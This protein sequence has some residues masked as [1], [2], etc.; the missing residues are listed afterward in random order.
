MLSFNNDPNL[1]AAIVAG[2][3]AHEAA[4]EIV[5]GTYWANG[6]GCA[7]GCTLNAFAKAT[8]RDFKH[9]GDHV[10]YDEIFGSGGRIIAKLEDRIFEGTSNGFAKTWPAR[11]MRSVPVGRDLSVVWPRFALWLLTEELAPIS[12]KHP[13]S[14][15][16]L[17]DVGALYREWCEGT[18]PSIER[19]K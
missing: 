2:I 10:V 12:A 8:G 13:K 15:A 11:L 5:H 9:Y 19:W 1:K 6:K 16:A 4:D 14:R 17:A 18:K 7:V 3:E